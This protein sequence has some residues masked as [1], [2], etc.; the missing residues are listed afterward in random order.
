MI[1]IELIIL[2]SENQMFWSGIAFYPEFILIKCELSWLNERISIL[3]VM[4]ISNCQ[5]LWLAS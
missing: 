4:P 3:E 2:I 1:F 5:K